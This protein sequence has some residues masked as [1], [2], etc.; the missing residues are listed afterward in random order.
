[1]PNSSNL[2]NYIPSPSRINIVP[3]AK[4]PSAGNSLFTFPAWIDCTAR[5]KMLSIWR[6]FYKN[7]FLR[8]FNNYWNHAACTTESESDSMQ[9]AFCVC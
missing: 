7:K 5:K 2:S 3:P 9:T 4:L 6:H 1:M 8:I